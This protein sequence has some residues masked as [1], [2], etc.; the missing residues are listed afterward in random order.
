MVIG[1]VWGVCDLA[2]GGGDIAGVGFSVGITFGASLDFA[3]GLGLGVSVG[4]Y[5]DLLVLTAV[6]G[7]GAWDW[8]G[9]LQVAGA[10]VPASCFG[11]VVWLFIIMGLL[12]A[13]ELETLGL[14]SQLYPLT[15]FLL[16]YLFE[17]E[18]F[19]TLV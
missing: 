16:L 6:V 1:A 19:E 13:V 4:L 17:S 8:E 10:P 18:S 15:T 2:T 9:S 7:S 14:C 3:W 12:N 11:A 5:W